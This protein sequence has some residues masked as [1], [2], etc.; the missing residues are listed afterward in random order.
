[1]AKIR[2]WE[3]SV[4]I[5]LRQQVPCEIPHV[6]THQLRVLP[7]AVADMDQPLAPGR[8]EVAAVWSSW[9]WAAMML[10]GKQL[11]IQLR[12]QPGTPWT[13]QS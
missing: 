11:V 10:L 6:A 5:H 7:G 1:M 13:W 3:E 9:S 4:G 8:E 2:C 12:L